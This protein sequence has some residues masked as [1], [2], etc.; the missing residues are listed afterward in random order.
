MFLGF[1]FAKEIYKDVNYQSVLHVLSDV[2]R[3]VHNVVND[4]DLSYVSVTCL[5]IANK[6]MFGG[7]MLISYFMAS[8]VIPGSDARVTAMGIAWP[9]RGSH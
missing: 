1:R 7:T 4:T 8:W 6:N 9:R 3:C 2:V 5:L